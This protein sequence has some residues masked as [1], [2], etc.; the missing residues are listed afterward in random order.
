MTAGDRAVTS[1]ARERDVGA[2]DDLEER[3][4]NRDARAGRGSC[5]RIPVDRVAG[6]QR[7]ASRQPR[8]ARGS[9]E[10]DRRA[11][12]RAEQPRALSPLGRRTRSRSSCP[13]TRCASSGIPTSR[14]SSRASTTAS[15]HRPTCS[16]CSSLRR[17]PTIR[18]RATSHRA[19]SMVRSSSRTTPATT[20]SGGS[21]ARRQS[22]TA[23]DRCIRATATAG[24]TSTTSRAVA[25]PPVTS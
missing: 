15:P 3:R 8:G 17:T 16:V 1:A 5:R 25:S 12:L 21:H 18:Q 19:M 13:R 9:R 24:S 11:E 7:R 10:G 22:S 23:A 4:R 6:R 20:S 2:R 14:R